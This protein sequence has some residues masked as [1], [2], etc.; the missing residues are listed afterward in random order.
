[1]ATFDGV[2]GAGLSVHTAASIG[3]SANVSAYSNDP[4]TN[5]WAATAPE[6]F[7]GN[8][9]NAP[10]SLESVALTGVRSLDFIDKYYY[11]LWIIP[12]SISLGRLLAAQDVDVEV[13]NSFFEE[14]DFGPIVATGNT[15]GLTLTGD[16]SGTFARLESKMYVLSAALLGAGTI[17]VRYDW[18]FEAGGDTFSFLQV[19]GSRLT[20]FKLRHNWA[21]PILE[22]ISFR[23]NVITGLSGNEQRSKLRQSPRRRI[24]MSYLTWDDEERAYFEN[25]SH[26]QNHVYAVPLWQDVAPLQTGIAEGA[27]VL[28]VDTTGRDYEVGGMVFVHSGTDTCE[29]LTVESFTDN[30]VTVELGTVNAYIAGAKVCPARFGI[31]EDK[32]ALSRITN[33]HEATKLAWLLDT[34]TDRPNQLT[35]YT[36]DTYLGLEIYD[37]QNDYSSELDIEQSVQS[38][39][40][41]NDIGLMRR[42]DGEA[43]PRRTHPFTTLMERD[44]FGALLQWFYNRSGK[45]TPFWWLDYTPAFHIRES[46]T[47]DSIFLTVK[48]NEYETLSFGNAARRDIA[49][50]TNSGWIYRHI[51]AVENNQNGTITL[52]LDEPP[53]VPIAVEDDPLICYL[54]QVR[55]D[56]DTL[57]LIWE[58]ANVIRSATRFIDVF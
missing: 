28:A 9:D 3:S 29:M 52:T 16:A 2:A 41:D 45:L 11:R 20:T 44:E 31:L 35:S 21:S 46:I 43:Y 23:T 58:T 34:D 1:M 42:I 40:L 14:R 10:V 57:E 53:G 48:S 37:E 27:L 32:L 50:R 55:L 39:T 51:D 6:F 7:G 54:R 5:V 56:S 18:Q 25:A 33:H 49:I 8:T 22:Q 30:S 26:W 38:D 24:E 15:D 36:P 12:N 13:W 4:E 17:D 47:L 19:L